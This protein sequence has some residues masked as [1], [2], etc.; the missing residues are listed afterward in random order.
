MF[1]SQ[2]VRLLSIGLLGL[3]IAGSAWAQSENIETV[4]GPRGERMTLTAEPHSL[5]EGLSV[6]AMRI[7]DSDTTR[8]A[9][10]FIGAAPDDEISIVSAG[11]P[12]SILEV[13][14]PEDGIGPTKVYVSRDT[15]LTLSNTDAARLVVGDETGE[16]PTALRREMRTII[17]NTS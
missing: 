9:F 5:A 6:R 14:R 3:L 16:L 4:E 13:G 10:S 12:Q 2:P 7:V 17:K 11:E 15:F 8:W 1:V